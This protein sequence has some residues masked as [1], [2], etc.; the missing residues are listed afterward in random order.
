MAHKAYNIYCL[1]LYRKRLPV[2]MLV[3]QTFVAFSQIVEK[4]LLWG[5]LASSTAQWKEHWLWSQ[6]DETLLIFPLGVL[7][8]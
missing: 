5:V 6:T 2:P 8:K 7:S 3:S 4:E 1:A